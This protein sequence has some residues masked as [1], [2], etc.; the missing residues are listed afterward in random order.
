MEIRLE[1]LAS[2]H[3]HPKKR[4]FRQL[5]RVL[6]KGEKKP[7]GGMNQEK[8][9]YQAARKIIKQ[10]IEDYHEG[11]RNGIS[12]LH[13]SDYSDFVKRVKD[14]KVKFKE[15]MRAATLEI[16]GRRR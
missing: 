5:Q 16:M 10:A 7:S 6:S 14:A 1:A 9:R 15:R 3:L 13:Y 11:V 8:I 12:A 4:L 2:R